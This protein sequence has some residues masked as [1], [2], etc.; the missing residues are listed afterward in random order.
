[1]AA[2][3]SLQNI[4]SL[5]NRKIFFD[6]NVL[7][8]IFWPSGSYDWESKYSSAFGQ[9]LRSNN[10]LVVDFTVVS[11]V[12][13]RA[14]R[15]EYEKHLSS[16]NLKRNDLSFKRFRDCTEGQSALEDIYLVV[17]E[18]ILETF[19]IN[20]KAFSKEEISSFLIIEPLDFTDKAIVPICKENNCILLTND[21][22]FCTHDIEILSSN[23]AILRN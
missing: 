15:I 17:K 23:P 13:N 20:G 16:N 7:I 19:S 4:S 3:Y 1:M 18:N 22:D 11:E 8:Y 9:L 14:V 12:I 10:Q 5:Q 6:A 21:K 2:R